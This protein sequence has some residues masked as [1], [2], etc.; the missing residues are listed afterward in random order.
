MVVIT[1]AIVYLYSVLKANVQDKGDYYVINEFSYTL[2]IIHS[3]F[4]HSQRIY[5]GFCFIK[6]NSV[7]EFFD[8]SLVDFND[9]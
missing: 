5:F 3:T 8:S 7:L 1:D 6:K 4:G 9:G 2:C